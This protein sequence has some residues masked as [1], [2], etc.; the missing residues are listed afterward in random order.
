MPLTLIL[1]SFGVQNHFSAVP[2]ISPVGKTLDSLWFDSIKQGWD[3]E[4]QKQLWRYQYTLYSSS[5]GWWPLVAIK[6]RS[7]EHMSTWKQ[8]K[9]EMLWQKLKLARGEMT[10]SERGRAKRLTFDTRPGPGHVD[11]PPPREWRRPAARRHLLASDP[12]FVWWSWR[13]WSWSRTRCPRPGGR[14]GP[15]LNPHL[16]ERKN[17]EAGFSENT[18]WRTDL[19]VGK[20]V[21][22]TTNCIASFVTN[23]MH[24]VYMQIHMKCV[25]AE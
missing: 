18:A 6:L 5:A 16:K 17:V 11:G 12:E 14:P 10:E 20:S 7:P 23:R 9:T 21:L 15:P 4:E 8:I 22:S 3:N 13:W 19:N 25:N 1:H 2:F 24:A